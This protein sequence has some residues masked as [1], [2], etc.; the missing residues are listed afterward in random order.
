MCLGI[1]DEIVFVMKHNWILS[2]H[3]TEADSITQSSTSLSEDFKELDSIFEI[4]M[5]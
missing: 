2:H 4:A 3:P 1:E 5:I